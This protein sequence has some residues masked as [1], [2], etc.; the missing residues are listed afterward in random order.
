MSQFNDTGCGTVT[1]T[2][3]IALYERVNLDGTRSTA[4]QQDVGCALQAGVAGDPIGVSFP[5][6]Q[7]TQ[8][9]IAAG[10]IAAGAKV[11][12]ANAGKVNDTQ[13]SGSFLRGIAMEAASADGDIIEIMP[14]VGDTAGS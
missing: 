11:Y 3:T 9:A 12:T 8:K 2:A 7:G 5:N 13:V 10:A 4:T 1:L 6:K 14:L